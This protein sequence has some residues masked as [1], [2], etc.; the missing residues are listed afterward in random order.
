MILFYCFIL[1]GS[2]LQELTQVLKQSTFDILAWIT[3]V[4]CIV[5]LILRVIGEASYFMFQL[6]FFMTNYT[7]RS[8]NNSV[9]GG[10][11]NNFSFGSFLFWCD[12]VS[13][14]SILYDIS[15]V[16]PTHF[17]KTEKTFHLD[18]DGFPVDKHFS[19]RLQLTGL[20][21][22]LLVTIARC[23]RLARFVG[24][25]TVV[26]ISNQMNW[27]WLGSKLKW[28][29]PC[30]YHQY[31]RLRRELLYKESNNRRSTWGVLHLGALSSMRA[32]DEMEMHEAKKP[33]SWSTFTRDLTQS[34]RGKNA[35]SH[36]LREASAIKIQRAWRAHMHVLEAELED[37]H[38]GN[39]LSNSYIGSN[40]ERSME[41]GQSTR[42]TMAVFG[43][44][45]QPGMGSWGDARSVELSGSSRFQS[46]GGFGRDSQV[47]S[48]M[49][50]RTGQ[51]VAM[52]VLVMLVFTVFFTYSMEPTVWNS[53]MMILH[54]QTMYEQFRYAAIYGARNTTTPE[55]F[56]Y[57]PANADAIEFD[58]DASP[59][60]L[61]REKLFINITDEHGFESWAGFSV[62]TNRQNESYAELATTCFVII[63]WFFG[64]T[65]FAGPVMS[66]VVIPIERMV[67]LLG[68]LMMDPL[69][70]QS[71]KKFKNFLIEGE[72][73][74]KNTKWTS[75][76][77]K[78]METSFL[79]STILRIGSLMK[80]GFG[81]AGVEI[82]QKSLQKGQ[83]KNLLVLTTKG[84]TVSCI[85]LF[86]DIR[87]FTDATECLQEEVFVFTNRIAA[88]VHSICHSYGG[89]A[90]KNVGDAFLLSWSLED[91]KSGQKTENKRSDNALVASN[92]QADKALLSV[93]KICSALCYDQFYLEP[94][95]EA[96]TIRLKE[97]LKKRSG[98]VVQL[99]FGLHAGKAVQG[100][101][102]S[103]RKI[104]ATYVSEAVERAEFLESSTKKYG[105][106]VLMSDSFHRLLHPNSRRRC[107]RIDRILLPDDD[108][109]DEDDD[110]IHGEL[111]EL[112]TF[113]MD[114][115][116][117]HRPPT[118]SRTSDVET[119]SDSGSV[120]GDI[121]RRF[122][123]RAGNS[124]RQV[125]N[126]R[127]S[128]RTSTLS[129]GGGS[130]EFYVPTASS[131]GESM[132][133][134]STGG[135]GSIPESE[136]ANHTFTGA[137]ELVLPTGPA[138]Y[139]HNV[140]QSPDMKRIRDKY[141]QGLFSQKYEAGLQAF[142]IKDWTMAKQCFQTVLDIFEDGP[143]LYF[144]D[145]IAQHGGKPPK[146][147]LPYGVASKH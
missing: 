115:A 84:S 60:L 96:A 36:Q 64:V 55:M 50:A 30:Y 89:A 92:N 54:N 119:I 113:D 21:V 56:I 117:I 51:W 125:R 42:E 82:I 131:V 57:K 27:Y 8:S 80:V 18:I 146:S 12:V 24:S 114:V 132:M 10:G 112:Y 123:R 143:S 122:M 16:N 20:E 22:A 44:S 97:K 128:A 32:H 35:P 87:Q 110:E 74:F 138:L 133:I 70:Y 94:L 28:L 136:E 129:G 39:E 144:M 48:D 67:R 118:K 31:L 33:W 38:S 5:E 2:Q 25:R 105:L 137:P 73:V 81:S 93:I 79:M 134:Q 3:F 61:D 53:T 127:R 142:Y 88:V 75:E 11:D 76:V 78:G 100:A 83:G 145:Q 58:I 45:S 41:F 72:D 68:M 77:L 59:E 140:W 124:T 19:S 14:I 52:G 109:G 90:N 6:P 104:D 106:Q 147:F 43:Q 86:C 69:G 130:D 63:V 85:F 23:A 4:F 91:R 9:V 17:S 139:S 71:T 1:F 101:I 135:G 66:L 15:H 111:M 108:Q 103:Q 34:F 29:N 37:E 62:R 120:S 40:M 47:G 102:G 121:A 7:S 126:R 141:V 107:R 65:A 98:P 13:T 26:G 49:R 95:S 46:K 99:G 116:A